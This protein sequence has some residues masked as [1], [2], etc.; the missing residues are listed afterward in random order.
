MFAFLLIISGIVFGDNRLIGYSLL[1]AG[2][3]LAIIDI[4]MNRKDK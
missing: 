4:I 1:G 3:L 2:V